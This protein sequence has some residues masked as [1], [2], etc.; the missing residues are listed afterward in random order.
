MQNKPYIVVLAGGIG[1]K[2]WPHSRNNFPKQFLDLLGTGRTLLQT[3]Y[4]RFVKLSSPDRFVVVTNHNYVDIVKEQLPELGD[5]QILSEPLRRNTAT[6]IAYA[7][8]VIRKRDEAARVI[9]TPSDHLILHEVAFQD[10][11]ALALSEAEKDHHLVTIGIKPNRPDTAYGYI[12]YMDGHEEVKKVKTFTEKPDVTLAKTFLESG[13]FVW[14]SGVFVWK[15]Q[16]IIRAFEKHM[17]EIAEV[18]EEGIDFY[19][20]SKEQEFVKRAYSLVKNVTI[21]LG[22]M[23]KSDDVYLILGDFGWS[24][25]G[26]WMSIHKLKKPGQG[27]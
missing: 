7:S 1:T 19:A 21:D 23:E 15:N 2:F 20:T 18:F 9:V 27:Q 5:D 6:C 11:I 3:T 24:D 8:Y 10:T 4:D 22:I 13:D 25:L 26:S 17:P 12:Q 16:S 14:N